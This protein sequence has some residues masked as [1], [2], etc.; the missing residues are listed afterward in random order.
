MVKPATP[1]GECRSRSYSAPRATATLQA[2][3]S[4][5]VFKNRQPRRGHHHL[6]TAIDGHSRLAYSELLADERKETASA[7][8]V[9]ANTYFSECGITVRKVLTD[10]GSCYRSKLFADALPD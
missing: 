10:N 6:H 7:F 5:G 4:S 8:W 1:C 9:R 3:K 2:D